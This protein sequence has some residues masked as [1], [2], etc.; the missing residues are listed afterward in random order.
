MSG[1]YPL[2]GGSI[3]SPQRDQSRQ[4]RLDGRDA[5]RRPADL[6]LA[7]AAGMVMAVGILSRGSDLAVAAGFESG[8]VLIFNHNGTT[9]HWQRAYAQKPHSQPGKPQVS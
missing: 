1:N 2:R 6:V 5:N 4:V 9:C 3:P 8:H 7:R